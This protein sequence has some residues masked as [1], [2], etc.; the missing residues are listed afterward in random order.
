MAEVGA[1]S[2]LRLKVARG[3]PEEDAE[4]VVGLA[5]LDLQGRDGRPG[6]LQDGLRLLD[7][8]P[9]RRPD[10]ELLVG[11]REDSLLDL[12]IALG[13]PDPLLG[14]AILHVVRG[15]VGE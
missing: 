13:D 12:N 7:V 14:H 5:Q 2:Q 11:E 10:A 8:E 9:G 1:R 6:L 15:D 3:G 4:R